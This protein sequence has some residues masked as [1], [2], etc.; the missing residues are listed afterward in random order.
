MTEWNGSYRATELD[1]E[2]PQRKFCQQS[3][4]AEAIGAEWEGELRRGGR[5]GELIPLHCP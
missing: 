1:T 5:T 4:R 3:S 2:S